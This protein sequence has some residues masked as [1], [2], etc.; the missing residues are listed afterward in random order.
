MKYLWAE[1]NKAQEYLLHETWPS[2][3]CQHLLLFWPLTIFNYSCTKILLSTFYIPGAWL[4]NNKKLDTFCQPGYSLCY[5]LG[6]KEKYLKGRMCKVPQ[7]RY[8]HWTRGRVEEGKEISLEEI[9]QLPRMGSIWLGHRRMD[10]SFSDGGGR[11]RSE[12]QI[13]VQLRKEAG[14]VQHWIHLGSSEDSLCTGWH[15]GYKEVLVEVVETIW[16]EHC[17]DPKRQADSEELALQEA[18]F[19]K[20][21]KKENTH[22][23][24]NRVKT[25]TKLK[26]LPLGNHQMQI[27]RNKKSR[28]QVQLLEELEV[29][30]EMCFDLFF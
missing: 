3:A 24:W 25:E 1:W 13:K 26:I 22:Q 30:K 6:G 19:L 17:V 5:S 2:Y 11:G 15:G 14:V 4:I 23:W 27:L 10:R 12:F 8:E 18:C 7:Q 29:G 21:K 9:R 20:K 16:W 28:S